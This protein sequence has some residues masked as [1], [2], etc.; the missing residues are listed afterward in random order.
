MHIL[1]D[2]PVTRRELDQYLTTMINSI[3]QSLDERFD[4]F[5]I[6]M[7][8]R[9]DGMERRLNAMDERFDGIDQRLDAMD[10]RFDAMDKRF[11]GIDQRLDAM[12]ERFDG[13]D[14]RLD[15]MDKRFDT[16]ESILLRQSEQL[17]ILIEKS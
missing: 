14:Q 2:S 11:D 10:K 8:G 16:V 12:D 7:A 13:I 6:E 9:F 5:G 15:A 4:E 17:R 3:K 1:D